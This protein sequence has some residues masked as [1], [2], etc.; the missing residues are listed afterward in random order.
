[1]N[2]YTPHVAAT[3]ITSSTA[4]KRLVDIAKKFSSIDRGF[5]TYFSI[6]RKPDLESLRRRFQSIRRSLEQQSSKSRY[7]GDLGKFCE[8]VLKEPG[9]V[10]VDFQSSNLDV[11]NFMQYLQDGLELPYWGFFLRA[12]INWRNRDPKNVLADCVLRALN[13][14]RTHC[15]RQLEMLRVDIVGSQDEKSVQIIA[16][17]VENRLRLLDRY[18]RPYI[19]HPDDLDVLRNPSVRSSKVNSGRSNSRPTIGHTV[20]PALDQRVHLSQSRR[21]THVTG[22]YNANRLGLPLPDVRHHPRLQ[23]L[24][25]IMGSERDGKYR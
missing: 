17:S 23:G 6:A 10:G 3:S 4:Q 20:C 13:D 16:E 15:R 7:I 1:M 21:L 8:K 11:D 2:R 14:A 22:A 18:L 9:L 24:R 25:H 19:E 12:F 5:A